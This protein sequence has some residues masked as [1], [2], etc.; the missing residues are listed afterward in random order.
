[1]DCGSGYDRIRCKPKSGN[2][3]G[4]TVRADESN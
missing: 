3:M 4:R 1:M 2:F